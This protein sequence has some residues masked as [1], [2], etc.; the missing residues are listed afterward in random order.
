MPLPNGTEVTTRV[1][2]VVGEDRVTQGALGR[3]VGH[4]DDAFDVHIVGVGVVRYLREELVPKKRGQLRFA[5]RREAAWQA[6]RQ[7]V[8]VDAIVGSRAWGLAD[9]GSDTDKRGI[10]ALPFEWTTSLVDPPLDLISADS[11][12][13]YWE[14]GKAFRQ[15]IGADPNT[16]EVLFVTTV[17]ATDEIG[18]WI[19]DSRDAFVSREIY[20]SFGRYALSQLDRLRQSTRLAEHRNL[21]LAWLRDDPSASLDTLATRLAESAGIVAPTARDAQH[22]A[23]DYIKQLYRSMYD[24]GLI[25]ARELSAL[26]TYATGATAALETPRELRP[27]NAYNLIRLIDAATRWLRTGTADFVVPAELAP[28]LRRIKRGEVPLAEVIQIAESMT[29]KLEEARA[30]DVLPER[31]DVGRIDGLLRRIRAEIARRHTS[32][33]PGPFG[34]G[35][36]E[37]ALARWDA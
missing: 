9:E 23:R 1:D 12:T 6:L 34:S 37:F 32:G 16:L 19:L 3:V 14:V 22:R 27:K 21:V 8:V 28:L 26:A 5:L 15:A 24:Q 18:Q 4:V 35:A 33:A 29:Q 2:R 10:F 25:E 20:G 13:T 36:P 11:S 7:C 17:E 30:A 31:P